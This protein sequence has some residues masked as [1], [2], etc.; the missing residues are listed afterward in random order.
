MESLLAANPSAK[1][2]SQSLLF[3]YACFEDMQIRNLA[4]DH[5]GVVRSTGLCITTAT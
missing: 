5:A 4:V 3:V 1:G 2:V